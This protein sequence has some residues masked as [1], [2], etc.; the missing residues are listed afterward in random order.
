MRKLANLALAV[1]LVLMVLALI[2]RI[3]LAPVAGLCAKSY[4]GLADTVLLLTIVLLL[5]E[6]R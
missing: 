4:I 6:K 1:G 3:R 5:M 2:C